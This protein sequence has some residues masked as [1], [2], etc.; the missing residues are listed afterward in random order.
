MYLS[1]RH[2]CLK[3]MSPL[4]GLVLPR[5]SCRFVSFYMFDAICVPGG[6]NVADRTHCCP[7]SP[8][9][10]SFCFWNSRP[11]PLEPFCSPCCPVYPVLDI[12]PNYFL[13]HLIPLSSL[14][15]A[16]AA[17]VG[18]HFRRTSRRVWVTRSL[19][20][21]RSCRT[22]RANSRRACSPHRCR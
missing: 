7:L 16:D 3:K 14:F 19:T 5:L 11:S 13:T 2:A 4:V 18:A 17:G 1:V 9:D 6:L 10:T 22:T 20:C 12:C 21:P 8:A 15:S